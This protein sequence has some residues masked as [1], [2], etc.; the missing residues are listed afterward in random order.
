MGSRFI[1]E[2]TI[3]AGRL[4]AEKITGEEMRSA[5]GHS[6]EEIRDK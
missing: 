5:M 1:L 6:V 3:L 4:E 2:A